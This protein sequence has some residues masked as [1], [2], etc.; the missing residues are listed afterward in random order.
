METALRIQAAQ[1]AAA[2][3]AEKPAAPARKSKAETTA[4]S[5][6][7]VKPGGSRGRTKS[8]QGAPA[9][10]V[11]ASA[12]AERKNVER[13]AT[14]TGGAPASTKPSW[15]EEP[16]KRVGNV[17]REVI[18]TEDYATLAECYKVTDICLLLTTYNHL[19]RLTGQSHVSETTLPNVTLH[20]SFVLA[21]GEVIL[22]GD[23]T[24]DSRLNYL[25]KLG[26]G[27][28]FIRNEIAKDEYVETVE[29][30]VGP[31][32]KLYTLVEFSPLADRQLLQ[33][34]EMNE[35]YKRFTF[36]GMGAGSVL[37]LLGGVFALLK[38]DTWTKGYYTKRLFIG[39]PAAIIGG[40]LLLLFW[41]FVT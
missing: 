10:N 38:F 34:W 1:L 20:H 32:K 7:T 25:A 31:M 22:N 37:C 4:A 41:D 2:T 27:I 33:R 29:R 39:V 18:V 23:I 19:M 30:S 28:D 9:T 14:G 24:Y 3:A 21:D 16:P 13:A 6:G 40:V 35:R 36:V 26:I 17:Q 11:A 15:A 12:S 5:N 8:G